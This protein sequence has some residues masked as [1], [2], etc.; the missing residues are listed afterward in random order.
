MGRSPTFRLFLILWVGS[1]VWLYA[2]WTGREP[3]DLAQAPSVMGSAQWL[4]M[5]LTMVIVPWLAGPGLMLMLRRMKSGGVNLPYAEYWFSGDRRAESLNRLRPFLDVMG[6]MM[7][8]FLSAVLLI[9][10]QVRQLKFTELGDLI[11][12]GATVMLLGGTLL[13]V[14]AVMRAFP[15]PAA[16]TR[17]ASA[18]GSLRRGASGAGRGASRISQR[19]PRR[20][21]SPGRP[22][23][24][25]DADR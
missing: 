1:L 8:A 15:A 10:V 3:A 14:R 22:G 5:A 16:E 19:P 9:E 12:L 4:T 2:A 18:A 21:G 13:W 24:P 17:G 25:G 20:P 11:V 6:S 23:H 7:A